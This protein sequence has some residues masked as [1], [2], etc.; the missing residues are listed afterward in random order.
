MIIF[1]MFL[2]IYQKNN[3][4]RQFL[5]YCHLYFKTKMNLRKSFRYLLI[6]LS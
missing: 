4:S 5:I 6:I 3:I 1:M 2:D